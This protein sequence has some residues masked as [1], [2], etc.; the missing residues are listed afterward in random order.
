MGIHHHQVCNKQQH[1]SDDQKAYFHS[2]YYALDNPELAFT[3]WM[4]GSYKVYHS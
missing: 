1:Q 2:T 3:E 4:G